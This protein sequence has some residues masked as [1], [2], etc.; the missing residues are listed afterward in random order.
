MPGWRVAARSPRVSRL[1]ASAVVTATRARQPHRPRPGA[2][3]A[4]GSPAQERTGRVPA[5][6]DDHAR[7]LNSAPPGTVTPT[8]SPRPPPASPC[9]RRSSSTTPKRP[10]RSRA[11]ATRPPPSTPAPSRPRPAA[12]GSSTGSTTRTRTRTAASSAPAATRATGSWPSTA[13]KTT[14]S[15]KP[16]TP[17]TP[18]PSAAE[19]HEIERRDGRPVVYAAHGSHASYLHAGTRDRL[20]PDPNDEADGRGRVT[21]AP[22]VEITRTNPRVDD[23]PRAV[24]RLPRQPL[25]PDGAGLSARP[26]L[27]ADPLGRG[28]V[29]GQRP[30][31][32]RRTATTVGECDTPEK[33]M[34]VGF[35]ALLGAAA[36]YAAACVESEAEASG[37]C[38][39]VRMRGPSAVIA[40]VN[41]KWAASEPSWE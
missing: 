5:A 9:S 11:S 28:D 6:A 22:V 41:S 29:R 2:P 25:H 26:V 30:P 24:G 21:I 34:T 12:S 31:T 16:S 35:V 33:A 3:G 14:A 36:A 10:P 32:A 8:C 13:S 1:A 38:H 40:I 23:R 18:A 17:S 27:P 4:T 37:W 20:W 7:A 39:G 15:S 19:P